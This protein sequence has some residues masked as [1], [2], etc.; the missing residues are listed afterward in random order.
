LL[1]GMW[2]VG[3]EITPG[4]MK[5]TASLESKI[6]NFFLKARDVERSMQAT[7]TDGSTN[8]A[9]AVDQPLVDALEKAKAQVDSSLADNFDT[10]E[11][12]QALSNL[13][14]DFNSADKVSPTLT[15][16]IARYVTRMVRIFGLDVEN[17]LESQ[18]IGWSGIV[19][20]YLIQI[21]SLAQGI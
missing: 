21:G 11:A 17:P 14:T 19:S 7:T 8:N 4:I 5:S 1:L 6:S 15:V 16:E 12:M 3:I 2:D 13:I 10:P 9:D 18:R 20:S